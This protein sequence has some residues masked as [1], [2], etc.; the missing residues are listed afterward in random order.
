[1]KLK[2]G[3]LQFIVI[4][5]TVSLLA[6]CT[7]LPETRQSYCDNPQTK[8]QYNDCDESGSGGRVYHGGSGGR[9]RFGSQGNK[10]SSSHSPSKAGRG[11]F[12]SF[13]RGGH[14]GG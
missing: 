7:R 14:A 8:Q 11:G 2:P 12:G 5:M 3:L 1:M 4:G 13:G 9:H 6:S 10:G